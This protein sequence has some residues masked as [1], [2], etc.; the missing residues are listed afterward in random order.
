MP[1]PLCSI[2][3]R[4]VM[5]TVRQI[6]FPRVLSSEGEH[7]AFEIMRREM[8]ALGVKVAFEEFV[9]PWVEYGEAFVE[10][11]GRRV[12]VRPL[13]S[14]SYSTCHVPIAE[15]VNLEGTLVDKAV[16]AGKEAE[17]IALRKTC[18]EDRLCWPGV[19][20][21]LFVCDPVEDFLAY[22]LACDEPVPSAWVDPQHGGFLFESVGSLCRL[23]WDSVACDKTYWNLVAEI[24]GSSKRDEV[25]IVGAHIDSWP[26]TVGASDNAW[27]SAALVEYA[28]WFVAHPP[29]RTVR[30]IWFTGEELDRRG[31]RAYATTHCH[32]RESILLYV[33]QDSGVSVGHGEPAVAVTGGS[34]LI[35]GLEELVADL[36]V[37]IR[38]HDPGFVSNDAK[39]FQDCGIPTVFVGARYVTPF[40]H[41]HLPTDRLDRLDPEKI[42]LVGGLSLSIVHAAEQ[43]LLPLKGK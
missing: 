20:A 14:P 43:G 30:L 5:Q 31:S 13:I 8:G 9:G 11:G 7:R 35:H 25:I 37:C 27:G 26:G 24:R 34:E 16:L 40:P 22:Y 36:G 18:D 2:G 1:A 12:P 28:G 6:H 41:P 32:D 42:R 21:Q 38:V 23:C 29:A 17:R 10:V 3:A 39:A 19:S 33:N 15:R 4:K